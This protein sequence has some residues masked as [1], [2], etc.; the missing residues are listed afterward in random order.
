MSKIKNFLVALVALFMLVSC[1]QSSTL[2]VKVPANFELPCVIYY[3]SEN[4]GWC[5][6]FEP[7]WEIVKNDTTFRNVR[8]YND[9]GSHRLFGIR[10]VPALVFI[11]SD[12]VVTKLV[13]Y[14]TE[15]QFR[16]NV[17]KLTNELQ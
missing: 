8:F 2:N 10:S 3:G 4:C 13:G 14:Q 5:K 15:S 6:K 9:A 11:N 12:S 7:N 17:K 1:Q 16:N